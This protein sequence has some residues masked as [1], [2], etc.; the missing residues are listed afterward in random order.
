MYPILLCSLVAMGIIGE[1]FWTLQR[2]R[3]VPQGLVARVWS[4]V[5]EDKLDRHRVEALRNGS[6]LGKIL[7]AGL[8][9]RHCSR[10]VMKESIEEVGGQ[11]VHALGRHLNMLG[12]IASIAPLLGLLG[13]VVGMIEVFATI[14]SEGVGNASAL[15]GGISKAL[16][17]TAAG[18]SVAIPSLF[19]YRYLRGKVAG[20][21]VDM[22]Q[23]TVR[24]LDVLHGAREANEK[25]DGSENLAS[26]GAVS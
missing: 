10:D 1:R 21:V 8:I 17:T 14:T 22:E 12:I 24:M 18:L 26:N 16:F 2:K 11:V 15:A 7:A 23:E 13:T 5:K 9:N 4:W 6:P 20:L 19:F 25:N 3:I